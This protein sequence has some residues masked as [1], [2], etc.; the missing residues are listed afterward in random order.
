MNYMAAVVRRRSLLVPLL[1]SGSSGPLGSFRHAMITQT[2][3]GSIIDDKG[4]ILL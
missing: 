3:D 4:K 2:G 1:F